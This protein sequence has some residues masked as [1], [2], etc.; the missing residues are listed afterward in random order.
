V[1]ELQNTIYRYL[2]LKSLDFAGTAMRPAPE[3]QDR[4]LPEPADGSLDA[5]VQQYEKRLI[6]KALQRHRWQRE[7]T[8]DALGI[9]R[10]TLFTKMK[11]HGLSIEGA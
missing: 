9:H 6:L 10:T 11:K 8:A 1:R 2:T 3:T 5:M 4:P 7:R